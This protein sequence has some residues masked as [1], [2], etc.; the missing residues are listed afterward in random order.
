MANT[1]TVA[2]AQAAQVY[3]DLDRSVD[4]A[5]RWIADAGAAGAQVVAFAESWLP[6]YPMYIFGAA[7]WNDPAAKRAHSHLMANAWVEGGEADRRL[8]QA[9]AAAGT[10]V[11]MP[12]NERRGGSLYNSQVFYG[13]DGTRLGVHRK[14]MPTHA[15]KLVHTQGDASD[16]H[17]FDTPA[18]RVGALI[19]WEHWMP[20]TRF[21]MHTKQEQIH[22][23]SWPE[24]PDIHHVAS[25]HYAFEGKCFVLCAAS[26][27]RSSDLPE[28]FELREAMLAGGDFGGAD[29]ELMP[30]GSGIIGPD[31]EWIIGPVYG[32]ETLLTAEIDLARITEELMLF[33]AV[34]HYNRPDLFRLMID[35]RRQQPL[36]SLKSP[37]ADDMP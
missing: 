22:I 15:E 23:A 11:V 2:I 29:D 36:G 7:A 4:K 1:V 31:G 6:G 30:G 33:D 20:L 12:C 18:G 37:L 17:V 35:E 13:P 24:A 26:Y 32:E 9:A 5:A 25:R 28:S 21:A 14:L 8:A 27:L 16:L 10:T 34:G 3:M 19:C